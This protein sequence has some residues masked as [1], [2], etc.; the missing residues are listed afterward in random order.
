MKNLT[1]LFLLFCTIAIPLQAQNVLDEIKMFEDTDTKVLDINDQGA[2]CGYYY[3]APTSS[4]RAFVITPN[5]TLHNLPTPSGSTHARATCINSNDTFIAIVRASNSTSL[6]G[7]ATVYKTYYFPE[8]D[9]FSQ[10]V[11]ITL[12]ISNPVPTRINNENHLMGWYSQGPGLTTPRYMWL[13]FDSLATKPASYGS[14]YY[15]TR[16]VVPP[17]SPMPSFAGGLN[18]N[19]IAAGYY[20][21]TSSSNYYS[22]IFD[23]NNQSFTALNNMANRQINDINNAGFVVGRLEMGSNLRAFMGT[24]SGTT[25]QNIPVSIFS[26][27]SLQSEFTGVNNRNEIVGNFQHPVTNKWVGFIYRKD[28]EQYR[29]PDFDYTRHTWKM[30]NSSDYSAA[31]GTLSI[32]TNKYFGNFSYTT[33]DP[34]SSQPINITAN[35]NILPNIIIDSTTSPSW[36]G[37]AAE[38]DS[39]LFGSNATN[40]TNDSMQY[41]TNQKPLIFDRFMAYKDYYFT[42]SN[43]NIAADFG[44]YCYGFTYTALQK[45]YDSTTY[46]NWFG[47]TQNGDASTY[48]NADIEAIKTIE[49]T[50]TKQSDG[51]VVSQY[52]VSKMSNVDIWNG[53]FRLK[54]EYNKTR[55]NTN[56]RGV[57]FYINSL[58]GGGWHEVMPYK[59]KTP[60]T[61]PFDYPTQKYDTLYI[62]DSNYP[63]D[64]S[65][66]LY[67]KSDIPLVSS[68]NHDSFYSATYNT[69]SS[70]YLTSL[71]FNEPGV[72]ELPKIFG[73]SQFSRLRP[74]S[75][76][77]N[78]LHNVISI[79]NSKQVIIQDANNDSVMINDQTFTNHIDGLMPRVIFNIA[80]PPSSYLYDT[81]KS[82]RITAGSYRT[83]VDMMRWNVLNGD[84]SLSISRQVTDSAEVDYGTIAH[85][86]IAYGTTDNAQ[87]TLNFGY[88]QIETN[89]TLGVNYM[90]RNFIANAND[91]F[92]ISS[93][94]DFYFKIHRIGGDSMTYNAK[95]FITDNGTIRSLDAPIQIAGNTTHVYNPYYNGPNGN[96]LVVYVDNDN[97]GTYN[98]TLFLNTVG[99]VDF[100]NAHYV[101]VYPNPTSDILNIEI[102]NDDKANYQL[103]LTD[104]TG[105]I[106]INKSLIMEKG[107]PQTINLTALTPAMYHL[108]IMQDEKIVYRE[109]VIKQ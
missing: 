71:N 62:Y 45:L 49:Q 27:P 21:N 38:V 5:G 55:E 6:N 85:K 73:H 61:I 108:V 19:G 23:V 1:L 32:W 66:C 39:L 42:T 25:L 46:K 36:W 34:H 2:V 53:L 47:I 63:S 69:S 102:S 106:I 35:T 29:L 93:P 67:V 91:S 18:E 81:T 74:T 80:V 109:K 40:S 75:L 56:P 3:Y 98:D 68:P 31:P 22:Y 84:Y 97:D 8:G 24:Y 101:T 64:S 83:P 72:K 86:E 87:K 107:L 13:Y 103:V 92:V 28:Q 15:A 52:G 104:V 60:N 88:I 94:E 17:T 12:S 26:A 77:Q 33:T 41:Q 65:Q 105:K 99:I 70:N 89:S 16:Y 82:L 10:L 20:Y 43:N 58:S 44:G 51:Y 30:E 100:E 54:N 48:S 96:Q 37:F 90:V 7:D 76:Y 11:S 9:T 95:L 79:R 50:Q 4:E 78:S 59:I 57:S 14:Q